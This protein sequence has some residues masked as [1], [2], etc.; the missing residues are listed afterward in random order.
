MRNNKKMPDLQASQKSI[1][2]SPQAALICDTVTIKRDFYA[3]EIGTIH[4]E[5]T[6]THGVKFTNFRATNG[7]TV[8]IELTKLYLF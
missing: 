8:I 3:G 6:N 1:E 7:D 4:G 2:A 5:W